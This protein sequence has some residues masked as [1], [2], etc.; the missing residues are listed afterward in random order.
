[1]NAPTCFSLGCVLYR[2]CA[3]KLPFAGRDT[4][5]MLLAITQDEPQPLGQLNAAVPPPLAQLVHQLLAKNPQERPASAQAVVQAIQ[6]IEREWV[7]QLKNGITAKTP[8][9]GLRV[10]LLERPGAK[11]ADRPSMPSLTMR[12]STSW[13][14]SKR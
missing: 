11:P 6:T 8:P 14:C 13:S 10:G 3:G 7:N 5:S 4:M 9:T 2:L 12:H 1:M